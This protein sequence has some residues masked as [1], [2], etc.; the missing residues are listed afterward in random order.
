MKSINEFEN[1]KV[2]NMSDI[3]G[4]ERFPTG[5]TGGGNTRWDKWNQDH[6]KL[7]TNIGMFDGRRDKYGS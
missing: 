6:S 4:G 5:Q 3:H 1:K 2:A 7:K